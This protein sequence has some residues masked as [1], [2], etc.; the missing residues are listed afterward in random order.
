MK[1]DS[2]FYQLFQTFPSLLFELIGESPDKADDYQFSSREIKELARRFDGVFLPNTES[3]NQIIYFL[4]VQFQPKPDFYWRLFAEI[5]VYL[6]Q[7][8]PT[9][10]WRAVAIFPS[11]NIDADVPRQYRWLA[12]N[13]PLIKVYLN[14]LEPPANPSLGWGMVQLV[15]ESE[16]TATSEVPQLL[17][18][19]RQ[20]L[21]DEALKQKVVELIE[22]IL[23]YKLPQLSP[24][25][26]ETMFGFSDL[27]QTRVYQEAR[28]EGKAE[29][30]VEGKLESV[31]RLLALGLSIEQIAQ[32]LELDVEKVRQAATGN[33]QN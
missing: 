24:Q 32:A 5:F 21:T 12:Q 7:Y 8:Q 11:R 23:V 33:N 13:P 19:A 29:G 30:R 1:T 9:N 17:A 16:E 26:L 14:E 20:E 6:A 25:E 22:T 31:P 18:K 28:E 4:E 27:K 2:I 15:I 3:P 10:D